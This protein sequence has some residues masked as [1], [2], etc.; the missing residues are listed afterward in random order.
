MQ[1]E[2]DKLLKYFNKVKVT[3]HFFGD[4][5]ENV[6]QL[7][8]F[9][10]SI[11]PN[12]RPDMYSQI[13]DI[14]LLL[15]HFEFDCTA[16]NK[17]GSEYRKQDAI[18]ERNFNKFDHNSELFHE[19]ISCTHSIQSYI[20]NFERVFNPHYERIPDYKKELEEK[21]ILTKE[22]NNVV[23]FFIEDVTCLGSLYVDKTDGKLKP[24]ILL[25][26]KQ[27][28]DIFEKCNDLDFVLFGFYVS[29]DY[30]LWYISKSSI[31]DYRQNEIDLDTIEIMDLDLMFMGAKI[32]LPTGD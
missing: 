26:S 18:V 13:D 31:G 29:S 4:E 9:I 5:N 21:N 27:F 11:I 30:H 23:G 15:E 12:D 16:N 7:M 20:Q 8:K 3:I 32:T 10:N 2:Y 6:L 22:A 28:L 1:N 25:H 19:E 17:S 14:V 24:V